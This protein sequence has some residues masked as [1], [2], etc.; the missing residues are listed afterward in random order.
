[1]KFKISIENLMPKKENT[2]NT[3]LNKHFLKIFLIKFNNY[4]NVI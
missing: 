3:Y 1:M 4:I 2:F